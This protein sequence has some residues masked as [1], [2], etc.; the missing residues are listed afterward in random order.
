MHEVHDTGDIFHLPSEFSPWSQFLVP[1]TCTEGT[2]FSWEASLEGR[3]VPPSAFCF[4]TAGIG[5]DGWSWSKH[6]R[7]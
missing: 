1:G 7:P 5:L 4:V 2:V 6:L 3:A